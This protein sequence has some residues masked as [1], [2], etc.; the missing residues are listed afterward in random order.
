M[1]FNQT[2]ILFFCNKLSLTVEKTN[3]MIF[4]KKKI[5]CN[6]IINIDDKVINGVNI[7]LK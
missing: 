2:E 4:S 1:C 5:N 6:F 7:F 3:L